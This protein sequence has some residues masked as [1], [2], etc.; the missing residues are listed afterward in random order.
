M[1]YEGDFLA[2]SALTCVGKNIFN[3]MSVYWPCMLK[4]T[5][6]ELPQSIFL[7]GMIT[8]AIGDQDE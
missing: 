5:E 4:I 3:F 2:V 7:H 6:P 1:M 8:K